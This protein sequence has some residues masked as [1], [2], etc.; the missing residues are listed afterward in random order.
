M[1]T[2]GFTLIE[3]LV[4]L[5]ISAIL[6]AIALPSFIGSIKRS[7]IASAGNSL[8]GA[9]DL[10]RSEAI[11]R[12]TVVV[13][14]RSLNPQAAAPTCNNAAG[15]G[16]PAGDWAAGWVT[17]AKRVAGPPL[18]TQFVSGANG[19]EVIARQVP[20]AAPVQERLIIESGF[21]LVPFSANG[22]IVGV[23]GGEVFLDHRDTQLATRSN[24]ARCIEL[25]VVGRA[26]SGR[27]V[28]NLCE[29][30]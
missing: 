21:P 11:R 26:R 7:E 5:T 9:M 12:N 4:V 25:S 27:V 17:F 23:V 19:D 6:V 3:V 18:N 24:M 13:V 16:Y 14:C 22:L 2:R 8:I 29:P 28:N 10:A 30:A 20:L 1:K 15:N